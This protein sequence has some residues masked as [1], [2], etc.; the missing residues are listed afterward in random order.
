MSA[1][2]PAP[3]ES[4]RRGIGAAVAVVL[5]GLVVGAGAVVL[6]LPH[7]LT[8]TPPA[9]TAAPAAAAAVAEHRTIHAML[10]YVSPDG[11]ELVQSSREVP[12]GATPVEQVRRILEA[13][14]GIAPAGQLSPI[15]AG[16]TIRSVFLSARGDAF[17]DFSK[18]LVSGHSGGT[19]DEALTVFAIVD[20]VTVNLPDI[21]GVQILVDGQAVDT[22]VGHLDL[23]HPLGRS[24]EWVRKGQ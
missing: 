10:F 9:G 3:P 12:F 19:L 24:L 20:A 23:R 17:V 6:I 22:L 7:W 18:E 16:T 11:G 14:V 4:S 15:P 2:P 1:R 5:A 13:E 8:P 21:H